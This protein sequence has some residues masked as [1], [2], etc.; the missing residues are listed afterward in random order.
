MKITAAFTAVGVAV[1]AGLLLVLRFVAGPSVLA[2][3]GSTGTGLP[4][5]YADY[6]VTS[7]PGV[8]GNLQVLSFVL[9]GGLV[10][11]LA[12]GLL[13]L[14]VRRR[15]GARRLPLAWALVVT[16]LAVGTLLAVVLHRY[17]ASMAAGDDFGWYAYSPLGDDGVLYGGGAASPWWPL[18]ATGA[19]VGLVMGAVAAGA[20][21]WSRRR[22]HRA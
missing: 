7:A 15:V 4:R 9:G 12:V 21:L 19:V 20:L 2:G 10:V 1:A 3:L 11:G 16:G 13:F 17:G 8:S 6:L 14:A 18:A 5:R 22:M